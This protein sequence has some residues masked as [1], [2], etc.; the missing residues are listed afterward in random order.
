MGKND[1]IALVDKT[2]FCEKYVL[3]ISITGLSVTII[4]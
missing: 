1:Y 3:G 2:F 4:L